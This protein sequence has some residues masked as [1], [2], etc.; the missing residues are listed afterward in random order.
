MMWT[1]EG[2]YGESRY[3]YLQA[4]LETK[5]ERPVPLFTEQFYATYRQ[6][7][8][9]AATAIQ[10]E[11]RYPLT[12]ASRFYKEDSSA[13]CAFLEM[14]SDVLR[15][16]EGK[17]RYQIFT[18]DEN[19]L[20]GEMSLPVSEVLRRNVRQLDSYCVS[21]VLRSNKSEWN[22][23]CQQHYPDW[24]WYNIVVT[25]VKTGK[26]LSENSLNHRELNDLYHSYEQR[27]RWIKDLV[28]NAYPIPDE[29]LRVE[30]FINKGKQTHRNNERS[31]A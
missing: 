13:Y 12:K 16:T 14:A 27:R 5:M 18:P 17:Y 24:A 28:A 9:L 20:V 6:E 3:Q 26:I 22:L 29:K 1:K 10:N 31:F 25:D 30:P 7:R 23:A 21:A 11:P 8:V 4:L 2:L 15:A 19:R